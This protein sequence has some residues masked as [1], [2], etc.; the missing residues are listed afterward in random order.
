M[1]G[2]DRTER[3]MRR[4]GRT[5]FVLGVLL[6]VAGPCAGI[7]RGQGTEEPL[8]E[9]RLLVL[10]KTDNTLLVMEVPSYKRLA[11]IPVGQEPH[12]VVATPDGRKAYVTNVRE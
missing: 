5:G 8:P 1:T 12:E 6:V 10:S 9:G 4:M 3:G 2:P 7:A 11:T